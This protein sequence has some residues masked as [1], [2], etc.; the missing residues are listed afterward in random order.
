MTLNTDADKEVRVKGLLYQKQLPKRMFLRAPVLVQRGTIGSPPWQAAWL[1][2][3]PGRAPGPAT[4]A[5][6]N[7]LLRKLGGNFALGTDFYLD[8]G[9]PM[10]SGFE[11]K[12]GSWTTRVVFTT[13]T[14]SSAATN[15]KKI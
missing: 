7:R 6:R 8:A 2:Q 4:N 5:W 1:W 13:A 3:A 12:G 11:E 14:S 15:A 10:V 9:A